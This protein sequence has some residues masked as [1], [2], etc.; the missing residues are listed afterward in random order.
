MKTQ[1]LFSRILNNRRVNKEKE[2]KQQQ[3]QQEQCLFRF[4]KNV[5][6]RCL[7]K[8]EM[9]MNGEPSILLPIFLLHKI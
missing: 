3:Q 5:T 8:K 2:E 9:L 4:D 1:N 7:E 6:F